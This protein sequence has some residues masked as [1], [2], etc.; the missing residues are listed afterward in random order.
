MTS[1]R[2]NSSRKIALVTGILFVITYVTSIPPVLFLYVPLLGDPRYIVGAGA[3]NGAAGL[4]WFGQS[5]FL[6]TSPGDTTVVLDPFNDIG[7]PVPPPLDTVQQQEAARMIR[8]A[9]ASQQ[10]VVD[11][12]IWQELDDAEGH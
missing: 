1:N 2:M 9:L 5:M 11:G 6:L 3:D 10:A 4:R 7:Y 8:R 12:T